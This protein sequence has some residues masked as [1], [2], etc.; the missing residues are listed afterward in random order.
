MLKRIT[1]VKA[2]MRQEKWAKVPRYSPTLAEAETLKELDK[3]WGIALD[4][5]RKRFDVWN[6]SYLQYRSINYFS[7]L[8]GSFPSYWNAWGQGVFIPLTFQAIETMKRQMKLRIPDWMIEGFTPEARKNEDYVKYITRSEWQRSGAQRE[9]MECVHDTILYGRSF[10]SP[11][12][13]QEYADR[14]VEEIDE[15]TGEIKKVSK[16]VIVYYGAA[17]RRIDPYDWFPEPNTHAT[18]INNPNPDRRKNWGFERY[19]MD[20]EI[21]RDTYKNLAN[22]NGNWKYL[23]PGGDLTDYKYLRSQVDELF[24]L[25]ENALSPGTLD[26]LTSI[27]VPSSRKFDENEGKIEVLEYWER[28]RHVVL[29]GGI[30]LLDTPNPYPHGEIPIVDAPCYESNEYDSPGVPE[31]V[32]FLQLSENVLWDQVLS[33]VVMSVHKMIAVNRNYVEDEGELTVRPLGIIHLKPQPG[34]RV[35]DA[36]Q[37]IDFGAIHQDIFNVITMLKQQF[38]GTTGQTGFVT[39]QASPETKVERVGVARQLVAAGNLVVRDIA[40]NIEDYLIGEAVRQMIFIIQKYYRTAIGN[41]TMLPVR[42]EEGDKVE[43]YAYVANLQEDIGVDESLGL[44]GEGRYKGIITADSLD[45]KYGVKVK[46]ASSIPLSPEDEEARQLRFLEMANMV[47]KPMV[48]AAGQVQAD[49]TTG[50]AI[51][52][53]IFD[54]EKVATKV[55]RDVFGIADPEEYKWKPPT[56][57]APASPDTT[58]PEAIP[59]ESITEEV[60]VPPEEINPAAIPEIGIET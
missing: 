22:S 30:I 46:G 15:I 11:H 34:V 4:A 40:R 6:Y 32:R 10:L 12:L 47:G 33:N 3:R 42:V 20:V 18:S 38:E 28:G 58:S 50:K 19:I 1:P 52:V 60:P 48:D 7:L 14:E 54:I 5:R 26:D 25:N 36:M 29:A 59:P 24:T 37:M 35:S 43:F 57:A 56:P 31:V 9:V 2:E 44:V 51:Q 13:R 23:K 41:E 55:A 21:L 16:S 39:G 53:P 49:P 27:R 8:Y 17:M 45:G